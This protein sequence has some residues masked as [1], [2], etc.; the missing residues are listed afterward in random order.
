MKKRVHGKWG[1]WKNGPGSSKNQVLERDDLL[2]GVCDQV[3]V[4]KN[5]NGLVGT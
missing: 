4:G 5:I 1:L 3:N 2:V